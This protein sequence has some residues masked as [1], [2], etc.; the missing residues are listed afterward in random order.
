MA[1]ELVTGQTGE[2][3]HVVPYSKGGKT[4]VENLQLISGRTN[5]MKGAFKFEPVAA[6]YLARPLA[7]RPAPWDTGSFSPRPTDS[8]G[9]FLLAIIFSQSLLIL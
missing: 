6:L 8:D 2:A 1:V 5:R 4:D 7:V 9:V 3:D